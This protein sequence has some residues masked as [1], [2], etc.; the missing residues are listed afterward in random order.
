MKYRTHDYASALAES[1]IHAKTREDEKKMLARFM[2]ILVRRGDIGR[3]KSILET[4]ERI[5]AKAGKGDLVTVESARKLTAA[6]HATI[7][8][9]FA[10]AGRIEMKITPHLVAGVR[11][12]VNDERELDASLGTK[13]TNLFT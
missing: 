2:K 3:A 10:H 9:S 8:K 4:A 5:L 12:S 11:V 13:L 7:E 1:L 6:Q